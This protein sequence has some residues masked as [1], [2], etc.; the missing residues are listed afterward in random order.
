VIDLAV[1]IAGD[2]P[3][4]FV[5]FSTARIWGT[6]LGL[7]NPGLYPTKR[8]VDEQRE[9]V[10][11]A[12]ATIRARGF[13]VRTKVGSAR[14]AGKAIAWEAERLGC[15]AIVVG[16]PMNE[17]RRWVRLLK[18]DEAKEVMKHTRIPV[19]TVP[20]DAPDPRDRKTHPASRPKK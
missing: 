11:A 16:D 8:E 20:I 5:V 17:T 6:R 10:E 18:G 13:E 9:I 19:H 14:S 12:A 15:Q 1:R 2:E 4:R 7:P 3:T